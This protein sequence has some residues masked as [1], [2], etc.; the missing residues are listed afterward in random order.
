MG[1]P[2]IKCSQCGYSFS[3]TIQE[4]RNDRDQLES[5]LILDPEHKCVGGFM[6]E[7]VGLPKEDLL[8]G[9]DDG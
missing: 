1:I 5:W 3:L 2:K 6:V 9:Q 4:G 7:R 8:E